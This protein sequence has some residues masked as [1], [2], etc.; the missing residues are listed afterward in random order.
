MSGKE[1]IAIAS[2]HAGVELKAIISALLEAEGFL[3]ADLGPS[4]PETSVDYPDYGQAVARMVSEGEVERGILICGTGIGMSITAN[5]FAGVRAALVHDS[6]TAKAT[7]EHNNANILVLGARVVSADLAKKLVKLW[8][9]T[10]YAGG[11]HQRRL[12]KIELDK[13]CK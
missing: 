7:K 4:D 9:T 1:K 8:L 6:F 10:E 5:K 2:D 13:A 11:R 3:V 12:D